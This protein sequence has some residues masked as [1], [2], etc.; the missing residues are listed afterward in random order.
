MPVM[1][2]KVHSFFRSKPRTVEDWLDEIQM[3]IWYGQKETAIRRL[4]WLM[5]QTIFD[6][7]EDGKAGK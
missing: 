6:E 7:E 3:D 4:I 2:P 5:D 1:R